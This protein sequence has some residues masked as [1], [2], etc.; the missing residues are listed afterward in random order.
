M[1]LSENIE[2]MKRDVAAGMP[3]DQARREATQRAID[4]QQAKLDAEYARI[5]ER[6]DEPS[7]QG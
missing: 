6:I 4:H 7:R 5:D 1:N 3:I 2:K